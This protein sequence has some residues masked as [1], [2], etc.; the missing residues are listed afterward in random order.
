MIN[1]SD[2]SIWICERNNCFQLCLF[3]AL[4]IR[5]WDRIWDMEAE[6]L[7]VE[8]IKP[9]FSIFL[10]VKYLFAAAM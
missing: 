1:F 7:D 4:E 2:D 9:F 5:P 6:C 8:V 3:K 10:D